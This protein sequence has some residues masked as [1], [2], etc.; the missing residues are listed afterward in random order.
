MSLAT[1]YLGNPLSPFGMLALSQPPPGSNSG[2]LSTSTATGVSANLSRATVSQS[3]ISGG[4]STQRKPRTKSS[5]QISWG[6]LGAGDVDLIQSFFD[7]RQGGGPYC[8]VDPSWSNF[9]PANVAG[10][11]SVLGALPE[12]SPTV[13]TLATSTAAGNGSMLSGVAQWSGAATGSILY[14]GL[15]NIIDGTWL[16]PVVAG[17]SVRASLFAK[18]VS[19]TA[20]LTAAAMAGT[21]GSAPAATVATGSGV[22]LNT[23]TWQEVSV[24]VA[25][26]FAWT[27][28]EDY[29][30]PKFT[31]SS[32]ASPVI[33]LTASAFVYDISLNASALSTWVGGVGV[34]RV[35]I[36]GDAPSPVD[37]IGSAGNGATYRDY[38][39]TLQE[40]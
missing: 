13:G 39:L 40:I 38:T 31:I 1:P 20:T 35:V 5:Y 27:S 9:Y 6:L 37:L 2:S 12:W 15:N 16:P 25:N 19:G 10:M 14:T 32:A 22:V 21:A 24:G 11:G 8:L 7:G 18:L 36:S 26:T 28:A 4:L 33:L 17:A 3:L 34:P 23:S 29:I 30:M